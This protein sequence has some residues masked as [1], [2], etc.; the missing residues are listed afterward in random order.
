MEVNI[1][2]A[3]FIYVL[4]APCPLKIIPAMLVA[5]VYEKTQAIRFSIP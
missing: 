1:I 4:H 2:I 5:I 3:Y